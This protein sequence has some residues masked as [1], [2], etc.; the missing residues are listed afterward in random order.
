MASNDVIDRLLQQLNT[1]RTC[2]TDKS[3]NQVIAQLIG[4]LKKI[5]TT[6]NGSGGG[7]GGSG[8]TINNITQVNQFLDFGHDSDREDDFII[9]GSPDSGGSTPV[10]DTHYD[11]PLSDGDLLVA[12]LIF[13]DGECIIVQ[14]PI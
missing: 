14:V 8:S 4:E 9:L 3:L 11:S 1:S 6:V 12:D 10:T 5:A 2:Q 7:G 13:A